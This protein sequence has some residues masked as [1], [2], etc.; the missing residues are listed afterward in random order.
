MAIGRDL[1]GLIGILGY[2]FSDISYLETALTHVSYANELK[3]RGIEYKSNERLEFLGD[4]VL[5]IVI[6]DLLYHN[7]DKCNEGTLTKMR[8][9]L[10]CQK[11]LAKIASG[12]SLGDY[13]NAGSGEEENGLRTRPRILANTTEAVVAAIYLDATASGKDYVAPILSLFGD[14]INNAATVQWGDYKS[15]LQMLVEK[16]GEDTL[17][18]VTEE[19]DGPEHDKVFTVVAKINSNEVGRGTAKRLKDAQMKAARTALSL[20]GINL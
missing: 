6:S 1:Q 3:A 15:L 14:E 13:I 17:E 16:S 9:Y 2:K 10:V 19:T 5:Q 4:A 20:F 8:Q 18:Y 12:L 11:T 7:F